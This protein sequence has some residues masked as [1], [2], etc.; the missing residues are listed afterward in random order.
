MPAKP[1]ATHGGARPGSGPKPTGTA[2][3]HKSYTLSAEAVAVIAAR[4]LPGESPS[5]T[6]DR[7]LVTFDKHF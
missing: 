1:N 5:A 4:A 3:L 7:L 2:K 6:L